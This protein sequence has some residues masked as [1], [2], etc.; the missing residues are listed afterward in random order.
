MAQSGAEAL[1]GLSMILSRQE[2]RERFKLQQALA[3]M[4][5]AQQRR[6]QDIAIAEKGLTMASSTNKQLKQNIATDWLS[7][8]GLQSYYVDPKSVPPDKS[9]IDAIAS[10]L[11]QKGKGRPRFTK[12]EAQNIASA[13]YSFNELKNPRGV[14]NIAKRYGDAKDAM[15]GEYG[16][17]KQKAL[18]RSFNQISSDVNLMEVVRQARESSAIE[19]NIAKEQTEFTMGGKLAYTIEDPI[20]M[21]GD[22]G[23]E[24]DH[25]SNFLRS[26]TKT[27][28]FER[29]KTEKKAD[30]VQQKIDELEEKVSRTNTEEEEL[31]RLPDVL[32]EFKDEVDKMTEEINRRKQIA[33]DANIK[34]RAGYRP[35]GGL[36]SVKEYG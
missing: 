3:L 12:E 35:G 36:G 1:Q 10:K 26:D 22:V 8:S 29:E 27:L 20:G 6:L 15:I 21:Y 2:E 4:Q 16:S 23:E 17:I 11:S 28:A 7:F 30:F 33:L 25:L 18:H 31:I 24:L 5:M 14:I 32:S 9:P 13:M 19:R 34:R